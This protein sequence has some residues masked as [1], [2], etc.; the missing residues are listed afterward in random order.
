VVHDEAARTWE[1]ENGTAC[2]NAGIFSVAA[3]LAKFARLWLDEGTCGGKQI[4]APEDVRRAL[5]ETVRSQTYDQGLGWNLNVF[6]WMSPLAPQGTAGHTGFTGPTMFIV[7]QTRHICII[8][9][10]RVYPTR[11]GPNRMEFHRQIAEWL[12]SQTECSAE[13]TI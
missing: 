8:L 7:P 4:I 12:L 10:N 3:D 11:N 5:S 2:G 6:S 13:P 1:E 9:N